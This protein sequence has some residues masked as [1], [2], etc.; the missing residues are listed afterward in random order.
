MFHAQE[1]QSVGMS[2]LTLLPTRGCSAKFMG[3]V[4]DTLW[5]G[6]VDGC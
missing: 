1:P 6:L 4:P 5:F 3:C 2:E